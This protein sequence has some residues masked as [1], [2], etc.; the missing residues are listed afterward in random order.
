VHEYPHFAYSK[1]TSISLTKGMVITNEPGYYMEGRFGIRIENMMEVVNES[2]LNK[3]FLKFSSLTLVPYCAKLIN[4]E[5]LR[6]D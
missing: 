6:K 4:Y 3:D 5:M 2:E 1:D